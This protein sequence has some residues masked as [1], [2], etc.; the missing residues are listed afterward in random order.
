M[1]E[2]VSVTSLIPNTIVTACSCASPLI[3]VTNGPSMDSAEARKR[4][5]M[6]GTVN[7]EYSGNTTTSASC[8][9]ASAARR[10]MTARLTDLSAPGANCAIADVTMKP[11]VFVT[12]SSVRRSGRHLRAWHAVH[13]S[14]NHGV[15][16]YSGDQH[17]TG[18]DESARERSRAVNDYTGDDRC[19]DADQIGDEVDDAAERSGIPVGRNEG[20][21]ARTCRHRNSQSGS[22]YRQEHHGHGDVVRVRGA[23]HRQGSEHAHHQHNSPRLGHRAAAGHPAVHQQAGDHELHDDR[24]QPRN[25]GVQTALEQIDAELML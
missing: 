22:A 11:P 15:T 24:D 18:D 8:C 19:G 5:S 25:H 14:E 4:S 2:A 23:R 21:D 12:I 1:W 9:R 7:I 3:A 6:T 16:E 17:G 20:H 10:R 13:P